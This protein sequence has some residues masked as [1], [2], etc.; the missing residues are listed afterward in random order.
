MCILYL[1][2]YSRHIFQSS[3]WGCPS[4]FFH[5]NYKL[6]TKRKENQE[7]LR[8][9][10]QHLVISTHMCQFQFSKNLKTLSETGT[11]KPR[12]DVSDIVGHKRQCKVN[13]L[14]PCGKKSTDVF[15]SAVDLLNLKQDRNSSRAV[16]F[17][18]DFHRFTRFS[19]SDKPIT[20]HS[21]VERSFSFTKK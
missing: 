18:V 20:Y 21:K 7:K 14:K 12:G 6:Q 11:G 8:Q 1:Y 16:S 9:Q 19:L 3:L 4:C 5:S 15:A 2:L 13:V 17:L 10:Q